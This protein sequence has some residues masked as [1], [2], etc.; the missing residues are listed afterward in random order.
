L[1]QRYE[2]TVEA[3]DLVLSGGATS[4]LLIILSTLLDLANGV[5]FL[6]EVTYMI[7]LESIKDFSTL[8]IVP[9]KLSDDG[10]D[11]RDLEE[12]II[13]Y[14]PKDAAGSGKMFNACY[15]TIPTYHNPTGLLFSEGKF[16]AHSLI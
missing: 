5:V 9:V 15:Y 8:K 6:D 7:A 1:S 2:S 10:V 14:K 3:T 4:G 11:I 13:K 16:V 12:K